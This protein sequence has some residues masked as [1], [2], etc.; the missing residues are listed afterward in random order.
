V[1]PEADWSTVFHAAQPF[2][3]YHV[4]LPVRMGRAETD[5]VPPQALGNLELIKIPNFFHLTPPAIQKHCE[6]LKPLCTA[7]PRKLPSLPVKIETRNY[8]FPGR[9]VRHEGSR[10]VVLSVKLGTLTLSERARKK[11]IELAGSCY[12]ETSDTIRLVGKRCPTR[13]QNR[14][15]VMYLLKVLY[16][17]S[18]KVEPWEGELD[19]QTQ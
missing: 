6:A 14:D 4:P 10:K 17:E 16:L 13:E 11:M 3:P 8:V 5:S 2:S 12:D 15:Y 7:W 18:N 19:Q 9:S 1:N